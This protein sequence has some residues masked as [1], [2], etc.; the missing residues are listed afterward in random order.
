[1]NAFEGSLLRD[2]LDSQKI[3]WLTLISERSELGKSSNQSIQNWAIYVRCILDQ[4]LFL[5][6]KRRI[7]NGKTG[8]G[9]ATRAKEIISKKGKP[10]SIRQGNDAEIRM[11]LK[12][13]I[14]LLESK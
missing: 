14:L 3:S 13:G 11:Q 8:E 1:M 4:H 12:E 5:G 10:G 2:V 7:V 9:I 6:F